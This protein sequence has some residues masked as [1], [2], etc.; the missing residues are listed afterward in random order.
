LQTWG[1]LADTTALATCRLPPSPFRFLC[2]AGSTDPETSCRRKR[3]H[4]LY[5]QRDRPPTTWTCSPAR[6]VPNGENAA[7]PLKSILFAFSRVRQE[8]SDDLAAY[9]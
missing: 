7:G 4:T 1:R 2:R 8:L 5:P 3:L 9:F 6:V